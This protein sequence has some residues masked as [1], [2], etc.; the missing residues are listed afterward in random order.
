MPDPK[1]LLMLGGPI[2]LLGGIA[3]MHRRAYWLAVVGSL[4]CVPLGLGSENF[5][6]RLWPLGLGLYSLWRLMQP[7][8]RE[9][10]QSKSATDKDLG[11]VEATSPA[12]AEP[13]AAKPRG[14]L[15]QAWDGWW[16]ERDR[17]L[18]SCVQAVLAIVFLVCLIMYLSFHTRSELLPEKD[19]R[20]LRHTTIE[21]GV[22][23]PWFQFESYP[24][25]R[26]PFRW[27]I[28]WFSS[29]TGIMLFGYLVWC[30][31]WQIEKAKAT[32]AGKSPHWWDGSPKFAVSIWGIGTILAILI[33][34]VIG[35]L[36]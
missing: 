14:T 34:F 1:W 23:D 15:G 27:N 4:F 20:R 32:A 33:A 9:A 6:I 2:V 26:T 8:V 12:T 25:E 5:V 13:A 31:N 17:W 21:Y 24:D 3:N 28:D 35:G 36:P 22:P 7:E 19:G 11:V 30:V 10:F 18:T 16:A 29:S